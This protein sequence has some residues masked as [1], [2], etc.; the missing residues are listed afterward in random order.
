MKIVV[1]ASSLAVNPYSGLSQVVHNLLLHLP[2]VDS[3]KRFILYV[4]CFRGYKANRD[5]SYPGTTCRY[6]KCPR[7]LTASWWRFGWPPI[8]CYLP[9]ADVFHSLHIQVPPAKRIKTV[10]TVHDCRYL[11]LPELYHP[12][13]I[14]KYK[15]EMERFLKRTDMVAAVSEF[16]RQEVISRFSFP[17]DRIRVIYNGFS[18]LVPAGHDHK[19][20]A[21]AIENK[22]LPEQYLLYTGVLDPRK[23]LKRLIEALS[24]CRQTAADFP[25]LVIAGI[26]AAEW[27]SSQCIRKA[28][29]LGIIDHIHLQGVVDRYVLTGLMQKAHGLCYPSL[30]E[31]FGFPPL[32]AMSLGVPVL[33]GSGSSIS[34]I[35]GS[36]ACLIDPTSVDDMAQGL[37]KM[38]FDSEYRQNLIE[39]GYQQIKRFSW[40]KAATEYR[41]LYDTVVG[42]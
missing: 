19:N 40:E 34:E 3:D 17:E 30:Y 31:G 23:N 37:R 6:I 16:T 12:R 22:M 25:D 36:A 28:K 15:K 8:D 7:R 41:K 39:R 11:A 21:A 1:D 42:G 20:D 35:S 13:Q 27:N 29:E 18:P 38:V 33:A 32:E 2:A 4:N 5:I 9:E 10:L 26:S 24:Q 14:Q